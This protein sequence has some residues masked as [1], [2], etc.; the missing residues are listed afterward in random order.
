MPSRATSIPW[1]ESCARS[2][3]LLIEDGIGIVDVNQ[4][5]ARTRRQAVEPLD[6]AAGAALRQMAD[7]A[8][9][10]A[11]HARRDHL[12]VG[13]KRPVHQHARRQPASHP[14]PHRRSHPTPARTGRSCRSPDPRSRGPRYLPGRVHRDGGSKEPA[15]WRPPERATADRQGR[16]PRSALVRIDAAPIHAA[17]MRQHAENRVASRQVGVGAVGAPDG[18]GSGRFAQHVKAGRMIDLPI[19]ENDGNDR[20]VAQRARRL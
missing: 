18:P 8:P 4:D 9:A 14:T 2:A 10:L 15:C 5:F 19:D 1:R 16:R 11:R 6:H 12:I 3:R 20:R 17:I 7:F 13:P